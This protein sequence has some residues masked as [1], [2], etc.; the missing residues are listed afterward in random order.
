MRHAECSGGTR[1]P[2]TTTQTRT[3]GIT[4]RIKQCVRN[5]DCNQPVCFECAAWKGCPLTS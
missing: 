3:T 1:I 4:T 5:G 2:P